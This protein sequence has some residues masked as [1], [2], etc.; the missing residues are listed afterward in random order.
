MFE[1]DCWSCMELTH[2][3]FGLRLKERISGWFRW[4]HEVDIGRLGSDCSVIWF[5]GSSNV[6]LI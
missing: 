2:D 6:S 4:L 3:R 5:C 1:L